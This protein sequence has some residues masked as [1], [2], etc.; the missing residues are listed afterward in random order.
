[1][2]LTKAREELELLGKVLHTKV[3]LQCDGTCC[4]AVC[5]VWSLESSQM[6]S[7]LGKL[8]VPTP[9]S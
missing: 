4:S 3:H 9:S 2:K 8:R 5:L 7:T 1:M 6:Q